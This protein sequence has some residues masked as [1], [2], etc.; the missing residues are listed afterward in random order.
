CRATKPRPG[1]VGRSSYRRPTANRR[2]HR[3]GVTTTH[4][5]AK[6]AA[7]GSSAAWRR[8][9]SPDPDAQ[10]RSD[11]REGAHDSRSRHLV[12]AHHEAAKITKHTKDTGPDDYP[13]SS[14]LSVRD[15]DRISLRV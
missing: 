2:S 12:P 7:G 1:R 5:C 13:R 6:T 14:V 10:K 3:A 9:T 11:P 15:R 8:M 4:S